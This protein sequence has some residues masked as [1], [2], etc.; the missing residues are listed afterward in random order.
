M[1]TEQDGHNNW[2]EEEYKQAIKNLERQK[3]WL[4]VLIFGFLIFYIWKA[5]GDVF[6]GPTLDTAYP[7]VILIVLLYLST[8]IVNLKIMLIKAEYREWLRD[9][10]KDKWIATNSD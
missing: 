5:G 9:F 8:E 1:T 10:R 7:M 3:F 2:R 6:E 4:P